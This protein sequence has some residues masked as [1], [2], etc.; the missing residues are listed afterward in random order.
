MAA[1]A[2]G[3][4]QRPRRAI[5]GEPL[6][7]GR[8]LLRIA[9]ETDRE[10][11]VFLELAGLRAH[12]RKALQCVSVGR[13]PAQRGLIEALG[14]GEVT[15]PMRLACPIEGLAIAQVRRPASAAPSAP[16]G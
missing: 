3:V 13:V 15:L 16:T 11:P 14:A 5:L 6:L 12:E 2:V 10:R 1:K 8:E 9:P 7:H 4:E